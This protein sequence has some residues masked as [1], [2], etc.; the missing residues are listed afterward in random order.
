M[1]L[2]FLFSAFFYCNIPLNVERGKEYILYIFFSL[3]L[4]V[5][6]SLFLKLARRLDIYHF[7]I[8]EQSVSVS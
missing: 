3:S 1:S 4:S 8:R 7:L 6:L 5:S 2:S